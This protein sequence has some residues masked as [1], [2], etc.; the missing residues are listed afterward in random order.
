MQS[1]KPYK[2]VQV[3]IYARGADKGLIE[4]L[5]LQTNK[6]RGEF[7][8]PV[9]G[10]VE[11]GETLV[12]A[13]LREAI[14]ETGF[15]LDVESHHP[16]SLDYDFEFDGK[17]GRAHE[18]GFFIEVPEKWEPVLDPKEHQAY[19]WLTVSEGMKRLSFDTNQ[20]GLASL[21]KKLLLSK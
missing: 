16:R 9:T 6:Q 18:H 12:E 5:F 11:Q 21:L 7:W 1:G 17:W 14:E 2:K 8:Q 13:A 3:W 15:K 20:K 19:E 4:V 10:K